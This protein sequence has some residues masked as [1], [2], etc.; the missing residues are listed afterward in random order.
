M[1]PVVQ[2]S[3]AEVAL[4]A[5]AERSD[6]VAPHSCATTRRTVIGSVVNGL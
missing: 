1:H 2:S 5:A 4:N 3:T 6:K